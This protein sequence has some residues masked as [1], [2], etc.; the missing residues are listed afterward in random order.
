[1][2]YDGSTT[3]Y[4]T[5]V[6]NPIQ[7]GSSVQDITLTDIPLGPSG[8]TNRYLYRTEGQ[9]SRNALAAAT[10][11]LAVTI[12]D[13]TTTTANDTTD[14]AT[15][16]GQTEWDTSG[17]SNLTPPIVKY[18]T[19]HKERL[20]GAN[21]P[22]YNS[23][24]FWSYAYKP[25]IF[26]ASD[27]DFVRIDDGD[28]IT[29]LR[30]QLGKLVIG[31]TNTITNFETQNSSDTYWQ[32]YTYSFVGCPAPYSVSTSPI[33][34]I[35]LGWDG[36]YVYNGQTSQLISDVV[37]KDIRDISQANLSNVAGIYFQNEYHLAYTSKESGASDNDTVLIYDTVR[38][39]Y[40]IDDKEI[41]CYTVFNSGNDFGTL[42]GGSSAEDGNVYAH[43]P[44]LSTLIFRYKSDF[45]AGTSDSLSI[46]GTENAPSIEL[47]WG[48]T[49]DSITLSGV[50][51]D[52]VTY[53][54]ATMDRKSTT[55]YWWS[56]EIQVNASDYDKLYWN[57]TLGAYGDIVFNIRSE[58]TE[59]EV[60]ADSL[61]WSS[62]F[63]D[64]AGSDVSTLTADDWIQL[65]A[66]LTTS[67]II[68]SPSLDIL[69]N[70]V[71]KLVYSKV[72]SAAE[73]AVNSLWKSG[74][75]D[76]GKPTIPKRIW[77]ITVYYTGTAGT[78]TV[79]LENGEGDIDT[80][81][82]IDLSV[83]PSDSTT[84]MYHGTTNYKIYKWLAPAN[85]SSNPTPIGRSWMFSVQEDEATIW[86]IFTIEVK[87]SDEEIYEY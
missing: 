76:F 65:R 73:T 46:G 26:S 11:Y 48:V 55:G 1:M 8:T 15:L 82:D 39:S 3:W 43:N 2:Y 85:S 28:E 22:N 44:A 66:T 45:Q 31:K 14:D 27:Y 42:Y 37:T 71:I 38:D 58:G 33:G 83:D 62:D 80:S 32:F 6:S 57:E 49:M 36:I 68:Y 29:F 70:Y 75:N 50:T 18:I 12:N 51:L 67:D 41:N 10:F 72:G 19:I 23:Y 54:S 40:V 25:D 81:F 64:P 86:N 56:P 53:E 9:A 34:I 69:N 84:D 7:T 13:N 74:Y 63:T 5:A 24:L 59:D 52:S 30:E 61:A 17:K 4:S 78:L 35:Y 21:K 60:S 87:Y 47:G 16:V 77:G 20:F 79:G